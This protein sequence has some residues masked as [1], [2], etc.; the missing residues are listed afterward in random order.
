[1]TDALSLSSPAGPGSLPEPADVPAWLAEH[2]CLP[3]VD[4]YWELVSV[5]RGTMPKRLR[6]AS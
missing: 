1:M 5:R 2:G 6:E 4:G 3:A